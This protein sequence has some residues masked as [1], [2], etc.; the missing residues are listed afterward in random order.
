MSSDR[1]TRI[2]VLL[3]C[4]LPAAATASWI[5]NIDFEFETGA[6]LHHGQRAH[7][8]FDYDADQDFRVWVQP[9]Y[10]GAVVSGYS[11]S[12]S[13]VQPA[14]TGTLSNWWALPL[15][16][17]VSHY[18]IRM[19]SSDWSEALLEIDVPVWYEVNADGVFHVETSDASPSWFAYGHEYTVDFEGYTEEVGG[20]LVFIRPFT[21]GALS[22][23]YQAIS[24]S[25][26]EGG[27]TDSSW[28]RFNSGPV[29]VDQLRFQVKTMDQSE[30][31]L[32]FFQ[33]VDLTW[34]PLGFNDL[35]MDPPSPALLPY[36]HHV[37]VTADY[38]TAGTAD[39]AF[40]AQPRLDGSVAPG[41]IYQAP[42]SLPPPGGVVSRYFSLSSSGDSVDEVYMRLY[43][44]G[45]EDV[46]L[47]LPVTYEFADHA[48]WNA[49][50]DIAG[51]AVLTALEHVSVT[52]DYATEDPAGCRI[53]CYPIG[54]GVGVGDFYY[55]PSPLHPTG[56]GTATV[57][58]TL[59]EGVASH[60]EE[61]YVF[62]NGEDAGTTLATWRFPADH[63]FYSPALVVDVP[64]ETPTR[65]VLAANTPNPFNP[66]TTLAFD[67]PAD[68]RAR[69]DVYDV[70]GRRVRRLYDGAAPAGRTR[71][72]WDGR[73]DRGRGLPSG[74]YLAR[75]A[76][77][78]GD[79]V[80]R[81]TLVR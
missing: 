29:H 15:D 14:G 50:F 40:Y 62:L 64:P 59:K 8:T 44:S 36:T 68:G 47:H 38:E 79:D 32:E 61:V 19:M 42:G 17:T 35:V 56:Q 45:G 48:L 51:P 67:L 2:L 76:S 78:L 24:A 26:P 1:L 39:L 33:P 37:D 28:F 12:G 49:R 54:E 66:S 70:Q 25:I 60:V 5:G 13:A 43:E 6:H 9:Y 16:A 63:F 7:V 11:W 18:R 22:P 3:I 80:R 41:Y 71:V 23:G 27:G 53:A 55:N 77:P 75:L 81:M 20:V 46:D 69:V 4:L 58:F 74:T 10:D 57:W 73:D 31:L 30:T 72:T 21:D 52:V 34:G 65:A